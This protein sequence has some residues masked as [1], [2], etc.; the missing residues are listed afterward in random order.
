MILQ[1]FDKG[2][3]KAIGRSHGVTVGIERPCIRVSLAYPVGVAAY[4]S[5]LRF[6]QFTTP[7]DAWDTVSSECIFRAKYVTSLC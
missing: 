5:R 1:Q 4:H 2:M 7:F 3:E 6:E